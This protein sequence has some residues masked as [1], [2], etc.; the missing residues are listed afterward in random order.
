M[1]QFI[2]LTI[3]LPTNRCAYMNTTLKADVP[4]LQAAA[5]IFSSAL[6]KVT[7]IEGMVFSFTMQPYP[8]SLLKRTAP[9]GG[10]VLGLDPTDGPLVS[11]L[12]L[13]Y[14]KNK[15]DDETV[16][17]TARGIIEAIDKDAVAKGTSV[18]FKYLNYAFD[19]QDPIGSY[20]I[21]NQKKLQDASRKYDPDGLFQKGVPG[22]FK[23]FP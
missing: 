19:F 6:D 12:I 2:E 8:L 23:I 7:S 22:G 21:E 9:A 4:T 17:S 5:D 13:L 16:L 15:S 11:V 10:N 1:P 14:W 20:G 3:G 18:R